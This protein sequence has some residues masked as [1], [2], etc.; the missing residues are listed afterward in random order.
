[1]RPRRRSDGHGHTEARRW[2]LRYVT[3]G[4]TGQRVSRMCLGTMMFGRRCDEA[5]AGRIVAAAL[6]RGV[7]NIDTA[8]SYA[9]G[10]TEEIVGRLIKGRRDG[11]FL[12]TKVTRTTDADW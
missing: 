2:S 3:F 8:A 6:E 10:A 9:D 12:G 7:D 1:M 5:E 4:R 11:L